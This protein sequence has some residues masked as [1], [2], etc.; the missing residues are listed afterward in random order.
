MVDLFL[1]FFLLWGDINVYGFLNFGVYVSVDDFVFEFD[2]DWYV[3]VN[4]SVVV[5]YFDDVDGVIDVFDVFGYCCCWVSM[6]VGIWEGCSDG[7]RG[8]EILRF[9]WGLYCV[10]ESVCDFVVFGICDFD[11]FE[12]FIGDSKF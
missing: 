1:C 2:D 6:G 12:G 5:E 4:W 8:F 11:V 10:F 7:V 3:D 9:W